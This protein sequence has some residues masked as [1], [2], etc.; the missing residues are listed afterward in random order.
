MS[1]RW[2]LSATRDS[3][4]RPRSYSQ[5]GEDTVLL[6]HLS[7][8]SP[9]QGFYLDVGA[10]HPTKISNTYALYRAG[11]GGIVVEPNRAFRKLYRTFRPRDLFINIGI[12]RTA[13]VLPFHH[14]V[15]AVLS[16]FAQQSVAGS[17]RVEMLP[18]LPLDALLPHCRP[19]QAFVLSIDVEGLNFEVL[20]SGAQ[21]LEKVNYVVIEYGDEEEQISAYL[22]ARGFKTIHRTQHNIIAHRA[23]VQA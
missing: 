1:L 23:G 2:W 5:N 3:L 18:V 15:W 10:N 22:G 13:G 20:Q 17:R 8:L 16:G 9:D 19:A 12:A 21:M 6:S 14:H 7:G 11:W 4:G